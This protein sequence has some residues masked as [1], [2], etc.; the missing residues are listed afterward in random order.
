MKRKFQKGQGLVE[1]LVALVIFSIIAVVFVSSVVN[2]SNSQV[3]SRARSQAVQYA[4]EG[5]E[6]AYN[7][8]YRDWGDFKALPEGLYK[9]ETKTGVV[10]LAVADSPEVLEGKFVR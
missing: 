3:V 7:V 1:A 8:S 6:I 4:R 10:S 5:L 2:L 9:P